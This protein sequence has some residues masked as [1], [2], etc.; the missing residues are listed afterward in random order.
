[1]ELIMYTFRRSYVLLILFFISFLLLQGCKDESNP[2][3]PPSDHFDPEGWL[4]TNDSFQPVLVVWQGEVVS[5]WEGT[6]VP[7]VLN[8]PL[9]DLSDH[10]N[11][12]FLDENSNSIDPPSDTDYTL[13][14]ALSD[15]NTVFFIPDEAGGWGFHLEGRSPGT[16]S[17]ELQVIHAG[18]V[19]I[20]TPFIP[21]TIQ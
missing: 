17:V 14:W 8:A 16:S 11:I 5:E 18:H 7:V 6:Q 19:D 4:L 20:R 21:I 9:N 1:M 3:T 10:Y 13:G 2:V 15:T 12:R